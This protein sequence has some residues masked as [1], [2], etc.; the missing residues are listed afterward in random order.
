MR[1]IIESYEDAGTLFLG[2]LTMISNDV[3]NFVKNDLKIFGISILIF[4]ILA[5]VT[6]FRQLR[7]VILPIS[8]CIVSVLVTSGILGLFGW[9]ITVISSNYIS[10]QLIFT[11]AIVVHLIV[12]YR[13]LA[14]IYTNKLLYLLIIFNLLKYFIY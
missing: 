6:I 1:L 2:G 13:E 4:I 14:L 12:R 9:E 3:V 10:L 7:W 5:L 11:M 8:I